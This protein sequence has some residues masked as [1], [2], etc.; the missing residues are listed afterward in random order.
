MGCI[1]KKP[2]QANIDENINIPEKSDIIKESTG[3]FD[4]KNNEHIE[5]RNGELDEKPDKKED[6]IDKETMNTEIVI[7]YFILN[8][9]STIQKKKTPRK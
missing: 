5:N 2:D 8:L 1:C 4:D 3:I 6:N 9:N 7:N